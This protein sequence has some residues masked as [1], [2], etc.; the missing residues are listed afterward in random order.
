MYKS[1]KRI[2]ALI[3]TFL[4]LTIM[5]FLLPGASA[6]PAAAAN[7]TT[8]IVTKTLWD[9]GD[10]SLKDAIDKANANP[11]LDTIEF[12]PG[13]NVDAR[14]EGESYLGRGGEDQYV[15]AKITDSLVIDGKG[16]ELFG[17]Q[18]WSDRSGLQEFSYCPDSDGNK[19][20]IL[21]TTPG[22][23]TLGE[24]NRD[25]SDVAV[26][27]RNMTIRQFNHVVYLQRNASLLMEDVNVKE[28]WATFKCY[29]TAIISAMEGASVTLRDTLFRDYYNFNR[30][31]AG[32]LTSPAIAGVN[33]GDLVIEDSR[34][35]DINATKSDRVSSVYWTGAG[36][37]KVN[38]VSSIFND[39]GG[40]Q[41]ADGVSETNIVNSIW[42]NFEYDTAHEADRFRNGSGGDMNI[43]ASTLMWN[44]DECDL[45]CN[46][47][48]AIDYYFFERLGS[49]QINFEG[50]AVGINYVVPETTTPSVL[51]LFDAGT[52]G[53]SA[54]AYT[55]MQPTVLQDADTLKTITGQGLL[56]TDP[57]AFNT[58]LFTEFLIP[59][60]TPA[61][62]GQLIDVIPYA[63][64]GEAN[65]LI[66]PVT[67]SPILLDALGN[68]RVE[69][70]APFDFRRN[71]GA[72][73]LTLDPHLSVSGSGDGSVDLHWN[74]PLV[75][76]LF[77]LTGYEVSYR[78]K[79]AGSWTPITVSGPDTL[80]YMVTGLTNGTEYEF[81]VRAIGTTPAGPYIGP[82]S[83]TVTATPLGPIGTP[84]VTAVPGNG[85]VAL[86]WTQPDLGGRSFVAYTILWRV[87]GTDEYT[88]GQATY[89]PDA[90]STTVTGLKNGTEYEFAVTA[91]ASGEFG[92]K[93]LATATPF[94]PVQPP[95]PGTENCTLSAG[96]WS[97]HSEY[98]P[99]LYDE[100]WAMLT[101]GADTPFFLSGQSYYEVINADPEGNAYYILAQQY[102][103]AELNFLRGADPAAV[104]AEF[105]AATALF[106]QY[107]PDEAAALEGQPRQTWIDLASILND[108]NNGYVGPGYCTG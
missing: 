44:S 6:P 90:T 61:P 70:V 88:G 14:N 78:V 18:Q 98:G 34:F 103:A 67:G 39:A 22:L 53:F 99:S 85:E 94:K 9:D 102:I 74:K 50:S 57:V 86:T 62:G 5:G 59:L 87:A 49:G 33:A 107:T 84:V 1:N 45:D 28:T 7:G 51:T 64:S 72:I 19:V 31:T 100:T 10:G 36:D 43:I 41:V 30:I 92:P 46:D 20:L 75:P 66:N 12:A 83:N 27:L 38:I 25:N 47:P 17:V 77:T 54:D 11:G 37:S 55:W 96:Y 48:N 97:T 81:E 68:P 16:G 108:Y 21:A 32:Y 104:Q 105:D 52:G 73:Q 106:G 2:V 95:P 93:G 80:E 42:N 76:E 82:W 58:P 3:L 13:I 91:N 65:E 4:L 71:I 40:V 79:D 101:N 56:L 35:E 8:Y 69:E 24:K 60:V 23:F 15:L 29:Q 89:S 63:G 26:T